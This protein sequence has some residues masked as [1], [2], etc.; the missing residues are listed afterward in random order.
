MAAECT[1]GRL[2][3]DVPAVRDG[4]SAEVI[5]KVAAACCAP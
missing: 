3:E 4:S 2:G 5:P 1:S